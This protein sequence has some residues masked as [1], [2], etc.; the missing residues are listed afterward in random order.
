MVVK[1]GF[2]AA[3]A[4]QGILLP[5]LFE[6]SWSAPYSLLTHKSAPFKGSGCDCDLWVYSPVAILLLEVIS[7]TQTD[8]GFQGNPDDALEREG[9]GWERKG[10]GRLTS[11]AA[12]EQKVGPD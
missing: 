7:P 2:P 10:F 5:Q 4:R 1:K 9:I 6:S 12:S 11:V 8:V 3:A